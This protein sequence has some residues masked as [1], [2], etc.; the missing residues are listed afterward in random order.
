MTNRA[1][2]L[3]T[4]ALAIVADLRTYI[5]PLTK[6]KLPTRKGLNDHSKLNIK[7]WEKRECWPEA[8]GA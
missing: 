1:P 6:N 7:G 8:Q 2:S 3:L 5:G 4:D